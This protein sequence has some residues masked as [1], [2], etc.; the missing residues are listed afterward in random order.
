MPDLLPLEIAAALLDRARISG[1]AFAELAVGSEVPLLLG[2]SADEALSKPRDLS[3]ARTLR[4][5]P[6]NIIVVDGHQ[7]L[8]VKVRWLE[9][10]EA[11]RSVGCPGAEGLPEVQPVRVSESTLARAARN[12][13]EHLRGL[14]PLRAKPEWYMDAHFGVGLGADNPPRPEGH[15]RRKALPRPSEEWTAGKDEAFDWLAEYG[16]PLRG[17]SAATDFWKHM[18]E[19]FATKRNVHRDNRTMLRWADGYIAAYETERQGTSR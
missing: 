9:T 13:Y 1:R 10:R 8:D 7:Y 11:L 18:A 17:S 16:V 12:P 4:L 5:C 3:R 2:R 15:R 6:D 14:A 19:W